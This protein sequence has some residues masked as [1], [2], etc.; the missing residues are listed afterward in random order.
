V[1]AH[2]QLPGADLSVYGIE[3]TAWSLPRPARWWSWRMRL[4]T[5]LWASWLDSALASGIDPS[6]S[7]ALEC[8]AAT[9][10]SPRNRAGIARALR[11]GRESA[12]LQIDPHDLRVSLNL[13][14]LQLAS[15]QL[16]ELEDTLLAPGPVYCHGVVM[17]SRIVGDGTGPLYAPRRSGELRE[18]VEVA[19]AALRGAL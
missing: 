7:P 1:A 8:R 14:E 17:A 3:D 4:L 2:R 16:I 11:E 18:R 6:A 9:I 5:R 19:L 13:A 12:G 15:R 10:L